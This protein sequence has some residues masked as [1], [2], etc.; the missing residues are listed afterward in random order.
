[1]AE[2]L[3]TCLLTAHCSLKMKMNSGNSELNIDDERLRFDKHVFWRNA[4]QTALIGFLAMVGLA[5]F[6]TDGQMSLGDLFHPII[7]VP[8]ILLA[9]IIGAI[10]ALK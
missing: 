4:L 10:R 5:L 7:L 2:Q 8:P 9:P 3:L 6:L 1:N